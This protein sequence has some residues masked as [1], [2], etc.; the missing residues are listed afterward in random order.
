MSNTKNT[1]TVT[2]QFGNELEVEVGLDGKNPVS[3]NNPPAKAAQY[4]NEDA[5][6]RS[7]DS[8]SEAEEAEGDGVPNKSASKGDWVDYAVSQGADEDEAEAATKD[9]LIATYGD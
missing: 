3:P 9:D 4:I 8:T 6:D 7:E 1:T 5:Y 2:D